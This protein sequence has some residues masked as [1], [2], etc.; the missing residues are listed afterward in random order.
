MRAMAKRNF[1][2]KYKNAVILHIEFEN[3]KTTKIKR[4]E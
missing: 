3:K 1:L 2:N 4:E